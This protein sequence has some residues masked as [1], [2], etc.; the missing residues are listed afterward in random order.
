M[1]AAL[2]LA[3]ATVEAGGAARLSFDR[4]VKDTPGNAARGLVVDT[5]RKVTGGLDVGIAG[6][7][8]FYPDG[9]VINRLTIGEDLVIDKLLCR[10]KLQPMLDVLDAWKTSPERVAPLRI[11]SVRVRGVRCRRARFRSLRRAF[12]LFVHAP[13]PII[14][15]TLALSDLRMNIDPH[16]PWTTSA[17]RQK[18]PGGGGAN[19]KAPAKTT[20]KRA[21]PPPRASR[22]DAP[23]RATLRLAALELAGVDSRMPVARIAGCVVRVEEVAG[24]EASESD[25]GAGGG[26]VGAWT[27]ERRG[28]G[29][30]GFASEGGGGG[31]SLR[32]RRPAANRDPFEAFR[33]FVPAPIM[34]QVDRAT[35]PEMLALAN[36]SQAAFETLAPAALAELSAAASSAEAAARL[37]ELFRAGGT[38]EAALDVGVIAALLAAGLPRRFLA[39][40]GALMVKLVESGVATA[41]L[42]RGDVLK[43]LVERRLIDRMLDVEL[44][45]ALLEKPELTKAMFRSG[46]IRGVMRN[47]VLEELLA[48]GKEKVCVAL[49]GGETVETLMVTGMLP[50]MMTFEEAPGGAT[51]PTGSADL[52]EEEFGRA[53]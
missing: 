33:R 49:L 4:A 19:A 16:A 31:G 35:T 29:V 11:R 18:P 9:V 7:L 5:L 22:Y 20:T 6:S 52:G 1:A 39:D 34:A 37:E 51:P 12:D 46:V 40:G 26:V 28:G 13:G 23:E 32:R 45:Q 8:R 27:D 24:E 10:A 3:R 25:A 2:D 15:Q 50:E 48:A 44:L 43:E 14:I 21:T 38:G 47:G 53:W 41:M 30:G 17:G 42:E 36:A